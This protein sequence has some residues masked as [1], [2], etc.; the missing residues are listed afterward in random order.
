MLLLQS[1]WIIN[2]LI[3]LTN[4][5]KFSLQKLKER[6]FEKDLIRIFFFFTFCQ[7][8]LK[9]KSIKKGKW[10]FLPHLNKYIWCNFIRKYATQED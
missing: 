6:C 8:R 2:T 3:L 7:S 4:S 1:L 5:G 9:A 10:G